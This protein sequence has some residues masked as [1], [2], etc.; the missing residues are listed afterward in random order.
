MESLKD[1]FAL[2]ASEPAPPIPDAE[3]ASTYRA[4][5]T[6]GTRAAKIRKIALL[7]FETDPFDNKSSD[8]ILPF[9]AVLYSEDFKEVIW[10]EDYLRLVD[11]IITYIEGLEENY[12]F[13]AHNG[14]RFD[15][16]FMEHRLRGNVSYKGSSMMK[17]TI[18]NCELRDSTHILPIA[19]KDFN[20]QTFD[21]SKL[22]KKRRNAYREEIIAYCTSDCENTL[23]LIK[24]F[25]ERNGFKISVGAAALAALQKHYK[26]E[27]VAQWT[28]KLLR[29][30][31]RGGRV[32]CIAGLGIFEGP[33]LYLDVNSMY[34]DVM[35]NCEHPVGS[36]YTF[37]PGKPNSNTFFLEIECDN[38]GALGA[39]DETTKELSFEIPHGIFKT[40]IH[41]YKAALEL[42]LISNVRIIE[43]VDNFKATNFSKFVLPRYADRQTL[44]ALL[45]KMRDIG[46]DDTDEYFKKHGDDLLIKFELNNAYGKTAQNPRRFK[47][48][49]FT[50]PR[51]KPSDYI[52]MPIDCPKD[53]MGKYWNRVISNSDYWVWE[54]AAP[55]AK[56]LNVG[57]GASITGAARAKLMR[58]KAVAVNPI[59]CDTDSLIC[60]SLPGFEMHEEKLGAWKIENHIQRVIVAGK[61]L[62]AYELVKKDKDGNSIRKFRS[63]GTANMTWD[64]MLLLLEGQSVLKVANGPTLT[65]GGKQTYMARAV[66]ATARA[67][68]PIERKA[69]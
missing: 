10:D 47:E 56:F 21:Y 24:M 31:F 39:Y 13:Y 43:C 59:Y 17:A 37:R 28:D 62:Y 52:P 34:P 55:D 32:E 26:I 15:F 12:I 68:T 53:E 65:R 22:T 35:A 69:S 29:P 23:R 57:T 25:V 48:H 33:F 38:N 41:E 18:G 40:T 1:Y 36:A 19:L 9:I 42:G 64:E 4:R 8:L 6:S 2:L 50:D 7:D 30:Y 60:E 16:R 49:H 11:K 67:K 51:E 45:K 27:R 61:K 14:G 3:R 66:R 58:A 46:E 63:K 44:K 54:R 20:K 5:Q